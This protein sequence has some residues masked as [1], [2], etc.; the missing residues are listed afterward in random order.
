MT[1]AQTLFSF[2][3]L[4]K[5]NQVTLTSPKKCVFIVTNARNAN[6]VNRIKSSKGGNLLCL[7][8]QWRWSHWVVRWDHPSCVCVCVWCSLPFLPPTPTE[9]CLGK[10]TKHVFCL[11]QCFLAH[12][13]RPHHHHSQTVWKC[14]LIPRISSVFSAWHKSRRKKCKQKV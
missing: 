9:K 13:H 4:Q 2:K 1:D 11:A 10:K 8:G 12:H 7:S 14:C 3:C 6:R 5:T